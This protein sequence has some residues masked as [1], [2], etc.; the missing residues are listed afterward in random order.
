MRESFTFNVFFYVFIIMCV[1]FL[2]DLID[3]EMIVVWL[4][5]PGLMFLVAVAVIVGI[6]KSIFN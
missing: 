3:I 1:L 2:F 5:I 6:I 4:I